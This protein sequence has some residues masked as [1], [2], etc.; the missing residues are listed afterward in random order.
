[1]TTQ[2][3]FK[4]QAPDNPFDWFHAEIV[5]PLARWIDGEDHGIGPQEDV[6]EDVIDTPPPK[7]KPAPKPAPKPKEEKPA[8]KEE[9]KQEEVAED[10]SDTE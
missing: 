9:P 6:E 5:E 7:P 8:P 4:K 10:G 3:T 2:K 1:M